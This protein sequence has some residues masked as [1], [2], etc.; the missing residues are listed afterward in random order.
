MGP[1]NY[2]YDTPFRIKDRSEADR[3]VLT[4]EE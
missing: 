1:S 3:R 4:A 2:L